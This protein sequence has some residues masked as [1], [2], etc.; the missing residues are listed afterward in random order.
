MTAVA[1]HVGLVTTSLAEITS[2]LSAGDRVET[3]TSTA[4][5]GTTTTT[6]TGGF[7]GGFGGG[8]GRGTVIIP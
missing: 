3:G 4:R 5:S 6:T 8:G 7:G 2:G 1:V